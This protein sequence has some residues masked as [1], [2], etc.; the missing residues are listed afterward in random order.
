MDFK[1]LKTKEEC[2]TNV[3]GGFKACIGR[4]C[5]KT[6]ADCQECIEDDEKGLADIRAMTPRQLLGLD[7]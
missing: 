3:C 7:D 2:R 1:Y 5:D 6:K 4:T